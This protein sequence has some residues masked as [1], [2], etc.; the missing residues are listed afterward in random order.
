M[1]Y[2]KHMT[3]KKMVLVKSFRLTKPKLQRLFSTGIK[4]AYTE[5]I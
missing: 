5:P 2:Q 3:Y 4:T 1:T